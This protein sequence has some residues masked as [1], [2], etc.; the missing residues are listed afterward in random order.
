MMHS[1]GYKCYDPKKAS[2]HCCLGSR[3]QALF[4][5]TAADSVFE[6]R[7]SVTLAPGTSSARSRRPA[8]TL[9]ERSNMRDCLVPQL[10]IDACKSAS[11]HGLSRAAVSDYSGDL[12][13]P[14]IHNP[15]SIPKELLGAILVCW[16][17][18]SGLKCE[19]VACF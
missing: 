2:A 17:F 5:E 16:F 18:Q 11:K 10:C 9:V 13:G 14:R 4:F 8:S 15:R 6:R 12:F 3:E 1:Q 19:A 7:L